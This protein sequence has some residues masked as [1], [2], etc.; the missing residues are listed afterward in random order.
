MAELQDDA[1]VFV[2]H[3]LNAA[4]EVHALHGLDGA[5]L[6]ALLYSL[7]IT[8]VDMPAW[9]TTPATCTPQRSHAPSVTMPRR[10]ACLQVCMCMIPHDAAA[11][12]QLRMDGRSAH[13]TTRS[14][15]CT[16]ETRS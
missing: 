2:D 11:R 3:D 9:A 12:A 15:R 8:V 7:A 6:L 5:F 16:P 14:L 1:A 4:V 13:R 10:V